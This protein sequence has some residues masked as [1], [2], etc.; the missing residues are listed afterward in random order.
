MAEAL[1]HLLKL[2]QMMG[3]LAYVKSIQQVTKKIRF[4][5]KYK[6][7]EHEDLEPVYINDDITYVSL[8]SNHKF[9]LSIDGEVTLTKRIRGKILKN[10]VN[11]VK[12]EDKK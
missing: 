3:N 1:F 2:V 4:L 10:A 8:V 6:R 9:P 12:I 7:G 11:I 5:P